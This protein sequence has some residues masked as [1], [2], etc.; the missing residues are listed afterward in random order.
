MDKM[1]KLCPECKCEA[2][3]CGRCGVSYSFTDVFLRQDGRCTNC[4]WLLDCSSC[5]VSVSSD[6]RSVQE[7]LH[8]LDTSLVHTP[9]LS[10]GVLDF[11]TALLAALSRMSAREILQVPGAYEVLAE[12]LKSEALALTGDIEYCSECGKEGYRNAK[13]CPACLLQR[14]KEKCNDCGCVG[15]GFSV[16]CP[17]CQEGG[18]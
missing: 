17:I 5:H 7:L 1:T 12:G 16:R 6:G 10:K 3:V 13:D 11:N 18:R 2:A 4:K 9:L 8:R 14:Q 15:K